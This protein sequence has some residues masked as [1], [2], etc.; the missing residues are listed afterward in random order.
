MPVTGGNPHTG[1]RLS[2]D[3][4]VGPQPPLPTLGR[5]ERRWHLNLG[6]G[7]FS[8]AGL[9]SHAVHPRDGHH[10]GSGPPWTGTLAGFVVTQN[11]RGEHVRAPVSAD[12][13][14][15]GGHVATKVT[16]WPR[17]FSPRCVAAG[18]IDSCQ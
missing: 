6:S 2:L 16:R 3:S 5:K 9:V 10:R 13:G 7:L 11:Q 15:E 1:N 4:A 14:G 8:G 17:G 18:L 12:G